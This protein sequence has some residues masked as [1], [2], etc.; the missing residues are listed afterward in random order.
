MKKDLII[1]LVV[2]LSAL[3]A[4]FYPPVSSKAQ[5]VSAQDVHTTLSQRSS[6]YVESKAL[7]IKIDSLQQ[8][9]NK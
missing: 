9:L 3:G 8:E 2:I 4:C 6:I 1:V 5:Y 7:D